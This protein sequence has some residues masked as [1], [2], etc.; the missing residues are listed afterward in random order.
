MT[1]IPRNGSAA[2][3][4]IEHLSDPDAPECVTL[5]Y[6]T[7]IDGAARANPVAVLDKAVKAGLLVRTLDEKGRILISLPPDQ[8]PRPKPQAVVVAPPVVRPKPQAP[9]VGFRACIWD[10]GEVH[11][12]GCEPI[13]ADG[14]R[15]VRLSREQ[16]EHL[17]RLMWARA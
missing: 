16:A 12:Y 1:Y 8:R 5:D 3:V 15:G 17:A 9:P 7:G 2:A 14:A 11:L 4:V 13:A 6:I 10:S